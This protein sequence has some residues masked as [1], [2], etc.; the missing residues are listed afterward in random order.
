MPVHILVL[1]LFAA[2]LHATWNA[3][4][5]GA[6]DKLL[7]TVMVVGAAG[8][9]AAVALPFL[10]P[11]AAASWPFIAAS[12][13]CETIY[14]ILLANAYRFGDM[15]RI[16]PL[17]RG[18][19]PLLVAAGGTFLIGETLSPG[20][21]LGIGLISFGIMGLARSSRVTGDTKGIAFALGNAT[22][23]A[24]YTLID[25]NGVRESG[26]I[27]A[28][29]M[30]TFVLP[31]IPLA[32]WALL[33]KRVAFGRLIAARAH[34]GLAGGVGT[35][36]AYGLALWAMTLAPVALVA[37]LRETSVLFA[38][39]ISVFILKEKVSCGRIAFVCIVA[40]GAVALRLA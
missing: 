3:L 12:A 6:D 31:A 8:L 17:M 21:W 18:T 16:Y 29:T 4:V 40:A 38:T 36:V 9:L 25:G 2:A 24:S 37:A 14:Y 32:A 33:M 7:T 1:V 13:I 28:Y 15:S 19:A 39:A 10:R 26:S 22:V 20:A 23:I 5:K 27:L 34:I 35:V 11:P 30:W